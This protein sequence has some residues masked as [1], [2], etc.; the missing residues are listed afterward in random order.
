MKKTILMLLLVISISFSVA[1]AEVKPLKE[2][3]FVHYGDGTTKVFTAE[4]TECEIGF[5]ASTKPKLLSTATYTINPNNKQ[6]LSTSFITNAIQTA[7]EKWDAS[8]SEELFNNPQIN[9]KAKWGVFDGVN[10]ITFSQF[11]KGVIGQTRIWYYPDQ[12]VEFDMKF[13]TVY[14]WADC[15]TAVCTKKMD[16]QNIAIHEFGHTIGLD[17]NY[18]TICN[19]ATMY[20]YSGYGET[21]KRT[22]EQ[23]DIT[24]EQAL[25]GS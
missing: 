22:L 6:G 5:L 14:L 13:N 19:Q 16:L 1:L 12:I 7:A 9:G 8:T 2:K 20:G 10:A 23:P 3:T 24:A 4:P 18:Y 25:Y 17:D 21:F 15:A 11:Q